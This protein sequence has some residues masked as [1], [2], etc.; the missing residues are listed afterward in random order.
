MIY[1][2]EL[3]FFISDFFLL[4]SSHLRG[5]VNMFSTAVM[6]KNIRTWHYDQLFI[7]FVK[8]CKKYRKL[9]DG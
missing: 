4:S 2:V 9:K 1:A 7:A 6:S 5:G 3:V 8:N